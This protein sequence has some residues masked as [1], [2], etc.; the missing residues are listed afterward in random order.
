[1]KNFIKNNSGPVIVI[2]GANL[3]IKGRSLETLI[4]H[5][6]NPGV[7]EA[8]PGGV[9]RNI[10]E[11]LARLGVKTI[12]LTALGDDANATF[13]KEKTKESGVNMDY[14]IEVPQQNSSTFIAILNKEKDLEV[15]ISDM[16]ILKFLTPQF[17]ESNEKILKEASIIVLDVSIPMKSIEYIVNFS[18]KYSIP[19]CVDPVS[20]AKAKRIIP[21][22]NK[23]TAITP[24]R[25]EAEALVNL[26]IEN[27]KDIV[28]IGRELIIKGIQV[29][30]ITLGAEGVYLVSPEERGF[31]PSLATIVVDSIGAGDALIAGTVYGWLK[32]YPH[33]LATMAGIAAATITLNSK[34][35]VNPFISSEKIEEILKT[36]SK[37]KIFH[38]ASL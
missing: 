11:N 9:A 34:E 10:A 15:G 31:I 7:I 8:S 13:I 37:N 2:G 30:I 36:L 26:K 22:L 29:A 3:D 38:P 25:N 23:I 20:V 19:L 18:Q 12:L 6:S 4:P 21:F 16:S 35:A 24:N 27:I 5:T 33:S 28:V 1:M 14:I 17:F 32:N